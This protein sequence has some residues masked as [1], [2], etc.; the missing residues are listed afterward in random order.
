MAII[1]CRTGLIE[2]ASTNGVPNT[3]LKASVMTGVGIQ[4]SHKQVLIAD[5]S[6]SV[7]G[8]ATT[9]VATAARVLKKAN[10]LLEL[11]TGV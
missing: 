10:N 6:T 8:D 9:G 5:L 7:F 4:E 11:N 3:Y 2:S 1:G